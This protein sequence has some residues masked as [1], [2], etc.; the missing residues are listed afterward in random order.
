MLHKIS[1]RENTMAHPA[2]SQGVLQRR[3]E[4]NY[5][6]KP[7]T[8]NIIT[9]VSLNNRGNFWKGLILADQYIRNTGKSILSNL[10]LHFKAVKKVSITQEVKP[11]ITGTAESI[12]NKSVK[13]ETNTSNILNPGEINLIRPARTTDPEFMRHIEKIEALCGDDLEIRKI[14]TYADYPKMIRYYEQTNKPMSA[15][16]ALIKPE[17]IKDINMSVYQSADSRQMSKKIVQERQYGNGAYFTCNPQE[18][19]RYGDITRKFQVKGKFLTLS[20]DNLSQG[21]KDYFAEAACAYANQHGFNDERMNLIT[22]ELVTRFFLKN[23]IDAVHL[24]DL[25]EE[26]PEGLMIVYNTKKIIPM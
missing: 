3:T 6:I 20:N 9:H 7:D 5:E 2:L 26:F 21:V 4:L 13:L 15:K 18:S 10:M 8:F 16:S 17:N 11:E 23:G 19:C 22:M 12:I 25:G 14:Y 1:Y 24:T